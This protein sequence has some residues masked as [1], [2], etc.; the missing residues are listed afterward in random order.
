MP[1]ATVEDLTIQALARCDEYGAS[2]PS[3]HSVMYRRLGVR[4]QQLFSA[5][6]RINPEYFGL[7]ADGTLDTNGEISLALTGDPDATSPVP[8]MELISK[9]EVLANDGSV[10][11]LP[12][13][14]EIYVVPITDLDAA[15]APRLTIRGGTF[16]PVGT[17]LATVTQIRVYYSYRPFRLEPDSESTPIEL[18]EPFHDLLVVD[19]ARFLLRKSASLTKEVR[20]VA[21]AALQTEEAESLANFLAHV[22]EFTSA[23][24]RGRFGRTQGST[25][26]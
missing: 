19:L 9:I 13:G 5:A 20:D 8:N 12:V 2:Y 17:D 22:K 7:Q 15:L 14:T 21:M 10:D 16:A 11:A 18:P 3:V 6:A 25:K 26:Q 23:V 24:E 1:N 4:Q